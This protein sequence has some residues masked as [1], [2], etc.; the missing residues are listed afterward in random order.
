MSILISLVALAASMYLYRRLR[1]LEVK[2]QIAQRNP[3]DAAA[4]AVDKHTQ[5]YHR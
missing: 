3:D 2:A 4:L 5:E 1:A